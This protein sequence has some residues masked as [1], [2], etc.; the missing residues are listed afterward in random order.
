M[1]KF[2]MFALAAVAM[3]S[4]SSCMNEKEMDLAPNQGKIENEGYG[5]IS[6]NATTD[7]AV[8]TRAN[9]V[10]N[11]NKWFAKVNQSGAYKWGAADTYAPI[12]DALATTSLPAVSTTVE[13]AN[14]ASEDD[15]YEVNPVAG[16]NPT[17]YYG[18]EY[19][20][21][22][23]TKTIVAGLTPTSFPIECGAPSN[24]KLTVSKTGFTGS[25][26]EVYITSPRAVTF[27][28]ANFNNGGVAYFPAGTVQ[29]YITYTFNN[30]P[31]KRWP[32]G[33]N[34]H[35]VT[36]TAGYASFLN[37]TMNSNGTISLTITTEG[38]TDED[39][40]S[41]TFDAVTGNKVVGNS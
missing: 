7:E 11:I 6:L 31:N 20:T 27:S 16:S 38:Y 21:G 26:L 4:V 32:A 12:T 15:A 1:K 18:T 13:V 2:F 41:I 34:T 36:L 37:F 14:F 19:W 39:E 17:Q 3:L 29:L 10:T 40:Q 22:S 30:V 24:S 8:A 28:G 25:A 33:E 9:S 5:Y 23:L 35:S